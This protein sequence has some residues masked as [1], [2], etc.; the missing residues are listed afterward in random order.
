V[1][2]EELSK[3]PAGPREGQRFLHA[4][5]CHAWRLMGSGFRV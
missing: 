4:R 5:A 3:G 1:L 2:D